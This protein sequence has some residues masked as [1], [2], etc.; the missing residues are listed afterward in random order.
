MK[1]RL[2]LLMEKM[3]IE[4]IIAAI[5]ITVIS[6]VIIVESL[7]EECDEQCEID[8][9]RIEAGHRNDS[10]SVPTAWVSLPVTSCG[11]PWNSGEYEK[12]KFHTQEFRK[13]VDDYDGAFWYDMDRAIHYVIKQYYRELGIPVHDVTTYRN[14][15]L[16]E[17]ARN[18]NDNIGGMWF[19]Q[20][21]ESDLDYFLDN[22]YEHVA[23]SEIKSTEDT[24]LTCYNLFNCDE[25]K[26]SFKDCVE[27]KKDGN[28]I[29]KICNDSIITKDGGCINAQFLDGT[30]MSVCE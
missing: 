16:S 19:L 25:T 20:I 3:K 1:T 23:F 8:R 18:C 6:T 13:T 5:I 11:A 29:E 10:I 4:I 17:G 26:P 7:P 15:S 9:R 22:G 12:T 28:T 27:T 24:L 14:S 2:L 21:S 30:G